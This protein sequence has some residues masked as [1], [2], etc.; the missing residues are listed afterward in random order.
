MTV[1]KPEPLSDRRILN[2]S[3]I[4]LGQLV[5]ML[6]SG[7]TSFAIG[8][9]V[10]RQT[11]SVTQFSLIFLSTSLPG[12]LIAPLAGSLV[13]RWDRRQLMIF[14]D[15][16]SALCTL[17]I[18]GL[19]WAG[20]L[21]VWAVCLTLAISAAFSVFHSLAYATITTM[22]IPPQHLARA[23]GI[24]QAGPAAAQILSPLLASLLLAVVS[25]QSLLLIDFATFVC[26]VIALLLA[27]VPAPEADGDAGSPRESLFRDATYGW[28]FILARPGL[29]GLL[30]L[31]AALNFA[32]GL[33]LVLFTPLLLSFTTVKMVGVAA[34]LGSAGLLAGSLLMG[35]WGGPK[36]RIYGILAGGFL[37]GLCFVLAGARQSF[38]LIAVAN[39]GIL[40]LMPLA[41][42]CSQA[43][44]QSK[45]PLAVQGRVFAVRM[46]FALSTAPIAY[47]VAGPLTE[48]VFTPLLNAAGPFAESLRQMIGAGAGRGIGLTF[49]AAGVMTILVS[50]I[51]FLM[52]RLRSIEEDLPDTLACGPASEAFERVVPDARH[53]AISESAKSD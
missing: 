10:Y 17:A 34:S 41:N 39:F 32:V 53:A 4:W 21:K 14:S 18:A 48:K 33:S 24:I 8:I 44:W 30:I 29:F 3:I 19:V 52:P 45:T 13:D 31:F 51:G 22:L 35:A 40:F 25:I 37:M 47:A 1:A 38:V 36:R 27:R 15:A 12:L 26:A 11:E 5:S 2:F 43:I 28:K 50:G 49:V 42:S 9:W 6:G 16:G 46:I 7:L 23:N 20:D